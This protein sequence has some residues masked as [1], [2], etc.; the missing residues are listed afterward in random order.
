M[1]IFL[2]LPAGPAFTLDRLHRAGHDAFVVGGC[3]RDSLAGLVPHD[4]DICTSAPPQEI[5]RVFADIP[6]A[7]PGIEYGT[8]TLLLESGPCEVTTFRVEQGYSD[9]RRP[10]GVSF[11]SRL[12][13]DLARRDFT[14]NAMA[15]NPWQGLQDPFGGQKDLAAGRLRCV[16]RPEVRFA[17]DGLRILRG[18]RFYSCRGL[19]PDEECARGLHAEKHR[20]ARVS[21]ERCFAELWRLLTGNQVEQVLNEYADVFFELLPELAPMAGFE[22]HN[23][24]HC[25]DV[26]R[27]T[28]R[29][30]ANGGGDPVVRLALL[31]HDMGK[32]AS[33]FMEDG[34]GHF[35]GHASRSR[36]MAG[37]LLERLRAPARL[38]K[39]VCRLVELHD[40]PIQ[41]TRPAIRRW[42]NKLGEVQLRRLLAI[43]R[44]DALAKT[45]H[46]LAQRLAI[47]DPAEEILGELLA[48]DA[49]FSLKDLAVKGGDLLAAGIPQGPQVGR[50]LQK[51]LEQVL[52]EQLP[53]QKEALLRAAL[54]LHQKEN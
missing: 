12:E 51:L 20:L 29:A 24:Y 7:L 15:W 21:A 27:H 9:G 17:E 46:V 39:E 26:W 33:F 14:V 19:V 44:A 4:W 47:L 18:L 8:V 43:H 42:L 34:V 10:D 13:E 52:A 22:Q 36:D 31:L 45:A 48:E 54:E 6:Q 16:G 53:N 5:C 40:T 25:L 30:V 2:S 50:L 1:S 11:T 32:P 38:T 37:P 35:Y 28:A 3:V 41:A 23:P 49:C